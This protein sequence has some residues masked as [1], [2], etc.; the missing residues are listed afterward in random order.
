MIKLTRF[1]GNTFYLNITHIETVEATPDTVITLFNDRKYIVK[2]SAESIAERV[3]AFYQNVH[4]VS[5]APKMPDDVN[6]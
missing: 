3:Q 4:P 1:N 6:E 2:D 5:S